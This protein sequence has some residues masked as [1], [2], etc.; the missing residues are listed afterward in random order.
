MDEVL[1]AACPCPVT[2]W[3]DLVHACARVLL[4]PV[5]AA[6][7]GASMYQVIRE[8]QRGYQHEGRRRHIPRVLLSDG[9]ELVADLWSAG[10]PVWRI[11]LTRQDHG[12]RA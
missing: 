12:P 1:P 5:G 9:T 4:W 6:L 11:G 10:A 8:R 2:R 7:V 3:R